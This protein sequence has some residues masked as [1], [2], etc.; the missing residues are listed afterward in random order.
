MCD[1]VIFSP[2]DFSTTGYPT[3]PNSSLQHLPRILTKEK[4][5]AT[6]VFSREKGVK[7]QR[8]NKSWDKCWLGGNSEGWSKATVW[9]NYFPYNRPRY[10]GWTMKLKHLSF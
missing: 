10:R 2:I 6:K 4:Q 7:A 3:L 5:G 1:F 9:K 8:K